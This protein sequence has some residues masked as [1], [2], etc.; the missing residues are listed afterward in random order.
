MVANPNTPRPKAKPRRKRSYSTP[1]A[2]PLMIW[3]VPKE[4]RT[5]FKMACAYSD[6]TM[7]QAIMRFMDSYTR[8]IVA[9]GANTSTNTST[10]TGS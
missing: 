9:A 10:N 5:R 4:L 6:T 8:S 2:A 3:N 7:R 1:D